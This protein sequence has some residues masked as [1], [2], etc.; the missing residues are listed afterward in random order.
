MKIFICNFKLSISYFRFHKIK[1]YKM[2]I[3]FNYQPDQIQVILVL[4]LHP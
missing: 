3:V 2:I 4:H 1:L